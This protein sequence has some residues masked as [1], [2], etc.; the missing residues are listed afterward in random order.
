MSGTDERKHRQ[1]SREM[2]PFP[3]K[4]TDTFLSLWYNCYWSEFVFSLHQNRS[5]RSS[6]VMKFFLK[7]LQGVVRTLTRRYHTLG[8]RLFNVVSILLFP[9]IYWIICVHEFLFS[10][11]N[12]NKH[13]KTKLIKKMFPELTSSPIPP[14]LPQNSPTLFVQY[15][16]YYYYYYVKNR[17]PL[18]H[19]ILVTEILMIG[20]NKL[21]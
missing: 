17:L 11:F 7:K 15:S 9:N 3:Q 20:V 16:L 2:W 12:S 21:N 1:T 10:G 6:L 14:P 13:W 5:R 4:T 8:Q 18:C 19:C